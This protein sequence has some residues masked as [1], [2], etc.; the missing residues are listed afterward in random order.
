MNLC[1][2][3]AFVWAAA[4]VLPDSF[5]TSQPT[6]ATSLITYSDG[7]IVVTTNKLFYYPVGVTDPVNVGRNFNS[8]NSVVC[9]QTG[10]DTNVA[11]PVVA[12]I[13]FAGY[14]S[15][16]PALALFVP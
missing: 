10:N 6:T 2:R 3:A 7:N 14:G 9:N 11:T 13:G 15:K 16:L 4:L 12:T 5:V 1:S 8:V